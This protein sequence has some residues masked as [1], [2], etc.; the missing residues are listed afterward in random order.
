MDL[1]WNSTRNLI[2]YS[3]KGH[4]KSA[5]GLWSLDLL[6]GRWGGDQWATVV[7][8]LLSWICLCGDSWWVP[9]LKRNKLNLFFGGNIFGTF[10]NYPR[11][12]SKK[13]DIASEVIMGC[14]PVGGLA[15]LYPKRPPFQKSFWYPWKLTERDFTW[16][17]ENHHVHWFWYDMKFA[18]FHA[19]RRSTRIT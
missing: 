5:P 11:N 2:Y 8:H 12:R 4:R 1:R 15:T 17:P 18:H 14:W 13:P 16:C 7:T 10:S 6:V 19:M 3:L 9:Y